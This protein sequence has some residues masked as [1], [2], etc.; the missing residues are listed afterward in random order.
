VIAAAAIVASV[1]FQAG[2]S[3]FLSIAVL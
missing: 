3:T 1:T 2:T